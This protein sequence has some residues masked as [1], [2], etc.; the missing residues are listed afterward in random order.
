MNVHEILSQL[1]QEE[2]ISLLTGINGKESPEVPRLGIPAVTFVDGPHGV[3]ENEGRNATHFPNLCCVAASWDKDA[4]YRMGEALAEDCIR[5]GVALIFGPGI[6]IKRDILCGRNFE[7][8]SEDPVIS[9]E[10]SAS[11]INGVQS[12]GIGACLKHFAVNNQELDRTG[13][14]AEVDERTMR[15]IYLK[16]FEI[17]V[18]K[19]APENIMCAYNKINAVFCSENHMLLTDILRNEWGYK[20]FVVSDWGAVRHEGRAVAAGIDLIMPPKPYTCEKVK[21][22]L[23]SGLLSQERLEE[24]AKRVLSF[25]TKERPK[26]DGSYDRDRQHKVAREVAGAGVVLLKN[27][28][29]VLPLTSKKYKKIACIG[30]FARRP[31][32]GGHGSAEVNCDP[33]WIESPL[34]ELQK[35]MPETEFIQQDVF[36]KDSLPDSMLFNKAW[37]TMMKADEADAVML[38]IGSMEGEF[39]E[40]TDRQSARLL[41]IYEYYIRRMYTIKKPII[42]VLQTGGAVILPDWKGKVD[43]IVEMWFGGEAAGG[44]VADVL[45]GKLNPSGRLPETFPN[46][47]RKDIVYREDFKLT[48]DEKLDVGYRYYDKHPEE[49][50]FPF[51][52]GL[53]YTDFS[54]ENLSV[55]MEKDS[56]TAEFMLTNVGDTDGHEVVQLYVGNP[57]STVTKPIKELKAFE[58]IFLQAG[59]SK[60]ITLQIPFSELAYYNTMLHKWVTEPGDYTVYV[61]ASSRDIRLT[62]TVLVETEPL[63]TADSG[64]WAGIG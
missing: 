43:A 56:L 30:E 33:S 48:Y 26:P 45:T 8:L 11:Y 15:E 28:N 54:Y 58:K 12:R 18:K 41:P 53:S 55:T 23:D 38:F 27:E 63:Y 24:A 60:K 51:G 34:E 31:V 37:G 25:V 44:A 61:G 7:Y 47:M 2:K 20:G 52:H 10:L 46:C 16:G 13:L 40:A 62:E 29:K 4:V 17:A 19:S 1:T 14:S 50:A 32:I 36:S 39:A 57:T 9:G 59:E 6:N 64:F 5:L 49:I 22:G 21:E 35:L 3:R 42:V